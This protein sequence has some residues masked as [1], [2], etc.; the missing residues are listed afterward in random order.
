MRVIFSKLFSFFMSTFIF[1][2]AKYLYGTYS[3]FT[4]ISK[5]T[6]F[7]TNI[8]ETLAV[9]LTISITKNNF[10]ADI[11]K[12]IIDVRDKYNFTVN[13]MYVVLFKLGMLTETFLNS[14]DKLLRGA[15]D[16]PDR[17]SKEDLIKFEQLLVAQIKLKTQNLI[18]NYE[19]YLKE[20]NSA[21]KEIETDP[22]IL[23]D[24]W[25]EQNEKLKKNN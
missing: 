25:L 9:D 24:R 7:K 2:K 8:L 21:A 15:L 11:S 18:K 17:F 16:L 23:I 3:T 19:L 22:D 20:K 1:I 5:H 12:I 4:N 13:E 10:I 14:P 6:L